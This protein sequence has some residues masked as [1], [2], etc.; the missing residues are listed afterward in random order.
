MSYLDVNE[1]LAEAPLPPILLFILM[2]AGAVALAY[3][4]GWRGIRRICLAEVLRDDTM[5]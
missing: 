2:I 5:M 4:L 1:F 3:F